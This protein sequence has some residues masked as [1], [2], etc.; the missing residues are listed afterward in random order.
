[1]LRGFLERIRSLRKRETH[2]GSPQTASLSRLLLGIQRLPAGLVF[3]PNNL[4]AEVI[5]ISVSGIPEVR[6]LLAGLDARQIPFVLASSLNNTAFAVRPA[7]QRQLTEQFDR[8]TRLVTGATRVEKSTKQTMQ[9]RVYIDPKRAAIIAPHET[10]GQRGHQEI[11]RFLVGRGW[12]PSAWRAVPTS[13]MPLDSYGNPRKSVVRQIIAELSAG[14]S[15]MRGSQRRCF[16]IR[17]GQY[18]HLAPGVYRTKSRSKGRSIMPLYLFVSRVVYRAR[19][20]WSDAMKD[21][22][23]SAIPAQTERA[24]L[25]AIETAR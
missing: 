25:R 12:M 13:S 6:A 2:G 18:S 10:G 7:S 4:E 22:A 9:A 16:V 11:E 23:V 24:V 21:A 20:G 15:G 1:M 8:P 5:D 19:L 14:I 3:R 17:P